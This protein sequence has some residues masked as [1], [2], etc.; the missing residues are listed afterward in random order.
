VRTAAAEDLDL[1]LELFDVMAQGGEEPSA[2]VRAWGRDLAMRAL[3]SRDASTSNWV[4][5]PEDSGTGWKPQ[6]RKS[7]DGDIAST[8]W[9]SLPAGESFT[10]T[11]KSPRFKIP[12][13][14]SFFIAGHN[15]HPGTN[16]PA[17]NVL[18][19]KSA[20]DDRVLKE[21][22]PPRNDVAKR[23]E[24]DLSEFAGAEAYLEA[25]DG[26][27]GTAYAWFAFG[28]FQ[29][30]VVPLPTVTLSNTSLATAA[31]IAQQLKLTELRDDLQRLS[32]DASADMEVRSAAMLVLASFG[33]SAALESVRAI[34]CDTKQPA[35]VRER[36]LRGLGTIDSPAARQAL[37]SAVPVAGAKPAKRYR[38]NAGALEV[39]RRSIAGRRRRRTRAGAA[40][41]G[42]G[43]RRCTDRG[44]GRRDERSHRTTNEGPA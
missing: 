6:R 31:R 34:V 5:S 42:A 3:A 36:I 35:A 11:L 43:D 7:A 4:A 22:L 40:A 1:Q 30:E 26:D 10:G 21:A 33:D 32:N 39:G 17:K 24:W 15:G 25:I 2:A 28:R 18:R 29:P 41:A 16:P 38:A 13:K 37:L 14:L 19:L 44:I 9:S 23:V 12:P 8:F 27:S 20:T